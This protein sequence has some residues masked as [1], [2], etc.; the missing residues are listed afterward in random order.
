MAKSGR[1]ERVYLNRAYSTTTGVR[2]TPRRLPDVL[3]VRKTGRV[4]AIEVPSRT[5]D[6]RKLIERNL[7]A[8]NQL[9]D[10]MQGDVL[11]RFIRETAVQ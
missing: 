4:D 2:T 9:P 5:D 1:Y 6:P 7:E 8:M 10:D 11:L 3:G